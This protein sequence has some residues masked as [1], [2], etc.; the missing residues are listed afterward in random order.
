MPLGI[1]NADGTVSVLRTK[2]NTNVEIATGKPIP[3]ALNLTYDQMTISMTFMDTTDARYCRA[4]PSPALG[5]ACAAY[6]STAG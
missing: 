3:N 4:Q 5:G 6:P 1:A 2:A